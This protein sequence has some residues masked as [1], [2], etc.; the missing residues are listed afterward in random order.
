MGPLSDAHRREGV[1]LGSVCHERVTDLAREPAREHASL[2]VGGL[3]G[4]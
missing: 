1:D 4:T 2:E 3:S